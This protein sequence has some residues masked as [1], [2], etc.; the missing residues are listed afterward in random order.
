[1]P[2]SY[3]SLSADLQELPFLGG[4][5]GQHWASLLR[6]AALTPA[7][8]VRS[9]VVVDGR[10]AA[11]D[12]AR[13][14]QLVQALGDGGEESVALV[15]PEGQRVAVARAEPASDDDPLKAAADGPSIAL[16]PAEVVDATDPW[17]RSLA[18]RQVVDRSLRRLAALGVRLVD[19]A[20]IWVEPSVRVAAGATLW[21]GS[22]L[23][24]RTSVARGAQVHAGAWLRDTTVG[25]NTVIKPHTVCDRAEI[26]ADCALGPSA[27]LRPGAALHTDVKVGNFVE[28]KAAVL[29]SGVRASHLSYIGDAEVGEG[30][31]VGAGTI[32]CNYDGFGKHR[33][34]IGAGA[35]VGSNT[36]LVAPVRIGDGV[37]IGAGS[38]ITRSVPDQS[39]AVERAEERVLEGRA[40]RLRERNRRRA[41][42][43]RD[44]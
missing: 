11:L 23:L 13:L 21:G 38:T 39:L 17:G 32:T 10:F 30:A 5:L 15:T 19:P 29:R 20:R 14:R 4:T 2:S 1:M 8:S 16:T 3:L 6:Q 42:A 24:G 31:N 34:E 18:E 41:E 25:E 37:I 28:V 35:F 7:S 36:S 22:V 27:H 33:T 43:R 9:Q 44:G 26:G 40:P 12:P